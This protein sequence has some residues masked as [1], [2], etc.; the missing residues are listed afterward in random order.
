MEIGGVKYMNEVKVSIII[1]MYNAERFIVYTINSLLAQTLKD[2]EILIM[3]D[4]STDQCASIV[5]ETFGDNEHVVYYKMEKNGGPAKARNKGIELAKGEYVTFLDSDDGI[6]IDALEKLY[7]AAKEFDADVV[8]SAGALVPVMCPAP[9]DIMQ[10]PT[11]LLVKIEKDTKTTVPKKIDLSN[12]DRIKG[13]MDSSL[14][15]NVWGKI[16]RKSFLIE[17]ELRMPDLKM[18]EDV[19]FSFECVM[20]AKN[21]VVTP[22][23]SVIYRMIGDSLSKGTKSPAFMKK[24]LDSTFGGDIAIRE[25]SK[26]TKFFIENPEW[27]EKLIL[28]MDQTME[29]LYIR[30]CYQEVGRE[31]LENSEEIKESFKRFF[32]DLAGYVEYIFYQNHDQLPDVMDYFD[33]SIAYQWLQTLLDK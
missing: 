23:Y 15:G 2:I 25:F 18:S 24:L 14:G 7:N 6:V 13:V 21:Y 32:G 17:N 4:C 33:N 29:D 3:D 8:Q 12:E 20:L 16:F 19:I 9:D 1:P 5:N 30:P 22:Y 11:N 10:S 28:W 31:A 27:T 26:K